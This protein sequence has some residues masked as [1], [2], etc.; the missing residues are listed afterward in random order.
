MW[1][2]INHRRYSLQKQSDEETCLLCLFALGDEKQVVNLCA[3]KQ[4]H[5][6][7]HKECY[8]ESPG[9]TFR[10]CMLCRGPADAELV[11]LADCCKKKKQEMKKTKEKRSRHGASRSIKQ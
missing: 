3:K 7:L 8:I 11:R 1:K 10:K 5:C 9:E 6:M 4:C 2:K